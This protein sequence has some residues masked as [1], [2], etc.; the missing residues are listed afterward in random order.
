MQMVCDVSDEAQVNSLVDTAVSEFGGL[1]VVCYRIVPELR[2]MLIFVDQ[3]VANAGIAKTGHLADSTLH[4]DY[5]IG[6]SR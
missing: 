5:S 2:G 1:E 6:M 4:I 3:M